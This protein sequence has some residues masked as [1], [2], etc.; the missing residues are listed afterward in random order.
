MPV[1]VFYNEEKLWPLRNAGQARLD[2]ED[3][4]TSFA[5]LAE[6]VQSRSETGQKGF[7]RGE[8][9][10]LQCLLALSLLYL[11]RNAWLGDI[12]DLDGIK[13][14]SLKSRSQFEIPHAF[15]RL[16]SANQDAGDL[17]TEDFDSSVFMARFGLLLLEIECQQQLELSAEEK[18]EEYGVEI[19]LD[20]YIKEYQEDIEKPLLEV[21]R[22]CLDF[23]GFV[24]QLEDPSIP[25]DDLKHRLVI[26]QHILK[27]IKEILT[28]GFPEIAARIPDFHQQIHSSLALSRASTIPVLS[29][30]QTMVMKK[31]G[32]RDD[33]PAGSGSRSFD[34]PQTLPDSPEWYGTIESAPNSRFP[35][36]GSSCLPSPMKKLKLTSSEGHD[37]PVLDGLVSTEHHAYAD[38]NSIPWI[39][40][41]RLGHGHNSIVEK[42]KLLQAKEKN[43][44][45]SGYYVRKLLRGPSARQAYAKWFMDISTEADI[46]KSLCHRHV[47]QLHSTYTLRQDYAII[48]SPVGD[49]NLADYLANSEGPTAESPMHSW[50]GCLAMVFAYLHSRKI[51]HRDVKPGNILIKGST[52]ILA[53]F[54]ISKDVWDEMTTKTTGRVDRRTPMYCAP[55]VDGWDDRGRASDIFSLGCCFLEMITHLLQEHGCTVPRLHA[56]VTTDKGRS[57][58]QSL[59]RVLSWIMQLRSFVTRNAPSFGAEPCRSMG[60]QYI[61][62]L[63]WCLAMLSPNP[64][65]RITAEALA[66]SISLTNA[67]ISNEGHVHWMG[68]CCASVLDGHLPAAPLAFR[69]PSEIS[70][71][72]SDKLDWL[73]CKERM[74]FPT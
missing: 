33:T 50:F 67:E 74:T 32:T 37:A 25:E 45:W 60:A 65:H 66:S 14:P 1:K 2:R 63:Q 18:A 16:S 48:M 69:W 62:A 39:A 71:S 21:L 43:G 56:Q 30:V 70:E 40:M 55:E 11:Y 35:T 29:R 52:V 6:S 42:V 28:L 72:E 3:I 57:Y 46:M 9:R 22:V 23:N 10:G 53:D 34:K 49:M 27:P 59:D 17:D 41:K 15:S 4:L 12:W 58:S 68:P 26:F 54:S 51:R 38:E 20:R 36:I 8:R 7:R 64:D 31:G 73:S 13:F 24:D 44:Q 61:P 19:A 47:V 5:T